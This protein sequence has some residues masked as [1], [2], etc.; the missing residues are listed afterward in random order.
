MRTCSGGGGERG[1]REREEVK[2]ILYYTATTKQTN[3]QCN[4]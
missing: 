3:K 4:A 2:V 1:K